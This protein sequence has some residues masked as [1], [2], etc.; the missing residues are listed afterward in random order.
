MLHFRTVESLVCVC[1]VWLVVVL[2]VFTYGWGRAVCEK[3][4]CG[5]HSCVNYLSWLSKYCVCP[6]CSCVFLTSL[7]L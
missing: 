6:R 1:G 2:D 3:C 5:F 4:R 7:P